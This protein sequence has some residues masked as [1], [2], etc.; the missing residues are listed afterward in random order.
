PVAADP[1]GV[2]DGGQNLAQ[3]AGPQS[4]YAGPQSP[5]SNLSSPRPALPPD[6]SEV[7]LPLTL[8]L[9]PQQAAAE[10][11][12][13][14]PYLLASA[15]LRIADR[16]SGFLSDERRTYLAALNHVNALPDFDNAT[17]LEGFD[18]NTLEHQPAPGAGFAPLPPGITSRW[19]KQA[20]RLL[21]EHVYRRGVAQVWFNRTLKL[22]GRTGESQ[23]EFRERCEAAAKAKRDAEVLKL[24]GQF[25]RR[26][27]T[28]QDRLA[29]EQR[30]LTMD[31]AELDARKREEVLTNAESI[32]NFVV[33][34][35]RRSTG[36][37]ISWGAYKRRQTQQAEEEVRESEEAI[38]KLNADLQ[39]IGDEY[40]AALD[41]LNTRW[42]S[43]LG[44]AQQVSIAPRKSDIFAD[45]VTL[46][47][48]AKT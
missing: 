28:L 1:N 2:E 17:G 29:R 18:P 19:L 25:E 31:R 47:W 34:R 6:V 33:G 48:V 27:A 14:Q 35:N 37:S 24:H 41:A 43:V 16:A 32:F 39:Q 3:Y 11:P 40:R 38:A 5:I 26:M 23:R 10:S 36:R 20:E 46:A 9:T 12:M 13:Y 7:F 42:M 45:I 21:V 22:Y 15:R 4:Q 8:P 30:E 44:D